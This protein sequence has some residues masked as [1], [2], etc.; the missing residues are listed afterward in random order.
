MEGSRYG[1]Q[2]PR[3][4]GLKSQPTLG[5]VKFV[6]SATEILGGACMA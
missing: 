3:V 6:E 4:V 2:G 5:L 1:L